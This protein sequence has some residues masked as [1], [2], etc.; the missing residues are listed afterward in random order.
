MMI[1]IRPITDGQRA[2]MSQIFKE[3]GRT[4][5]SLV[6]DTVENA[7]DSLRF[8]GDHMEDITRGDLDRVISSYHRKLKEA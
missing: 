1:D 2:T 7:S 6:C 8:C 5:Q 3:S 4:F